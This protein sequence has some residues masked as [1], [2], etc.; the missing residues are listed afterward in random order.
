MTEFYV[1]HHGWQ[2]A[3][4]G[5]GTWQE[6]YHNDVLASRCKLDTGK[7]DYTLF[8]HNWGGIRYLS[9]IV[10]LPFE[11]VSMYSVDGRDVEDALVQ[12]IIDKLHLWT[13]SFTDFNRNPCLKQIGCIGS[14]EESCQELAG[15]WVVP[16]IDGYTSEKAPVCA[17]HAECYRDGFKGCPF[18]PEPISIERNKKIY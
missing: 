3:P 2:T 4:H 14:Y 6:S 11:R 17:K 9:R 18:W 7:M 5:I 10:D 13:T 12:E 1:P 15:F 16:A 8:L